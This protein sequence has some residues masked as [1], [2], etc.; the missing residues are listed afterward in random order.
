MEEVPRLFERRLQVFAFLLFGS[1]LQ[2]EWRRLLGF[3]DLNG[4]D[5]WVFFDLNGEIA[6][7]LLFE[8]SRLLGFCDLGRFWDLNGEGC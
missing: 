1:I 3:F 6:G 5:C 7:F 4:G 2:F 8:W